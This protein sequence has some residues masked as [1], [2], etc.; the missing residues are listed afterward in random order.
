MTGVMSKRLNTTLLFAAATKAIAGCGNKNH[1]VTQAEKKDV[2]AGETRPG[3]KKAFRSETQFA[4][5]RFRL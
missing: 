2:V 3:I 1:A 5:A 4:P